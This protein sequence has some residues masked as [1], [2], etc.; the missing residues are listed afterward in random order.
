MKNIKEVHPVLLLTLIAVVFV[1]SYVSTSYVSAQNQSIYYCKSRI[2]TGTPDTRYFQCSTNSS[3]TVDPGSAVSSCEVSSDDPGCRTRTI[4]L[5]I[6]NFLGNHYCSYGWSYYPSAGTPSSNFQCVA[7]PPPPSVFDFSLSNGGDKSVSQGQTTTN[8]VTVT[9]ITSASSIPVAFSVF[10]LPPES[11]TSFLPVSC[12]P[13][14]SGTMTCVTTITITTALS[15]PAGSYPIIVMG[16]SETPPAGFPDQSV[17]ALGHC[18]GVTTSFY[19]TISIKNQNSNK[20]YFRRTS[21]N[22]TCPTCQ[23]T[24][25]TDFEV[26]ANTTLAKGGFGN[27]TYSSP[28]CNIEVPA[29]KYGPGNGSATYSVSFTVG[30]PAVN[31][32]TYS[33]NYSI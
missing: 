18:N 29:S 26:D 6:R 15:T 13:P 24:A 10:E 27:L 31:T 1:A 14:G 17:M 8:T 19:G 21:F 9:K 25:P 20:V 7:A 4:S 23:D 2:I 32:V 11:T 16:T 30:G 28:G 3:F 5:M 12:T 33:W 22:P